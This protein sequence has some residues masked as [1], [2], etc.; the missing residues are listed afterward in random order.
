MN[1]FKNIN[2]STVFIFTVVTIIIIAGLWWLFQK[3]D[4]NDGQLRLYGNVDIREVQMAF[5]QPG[6]IAQMHFDEGDSVMPGMTLATLDDQPYQDTLASAQA[7]VWL[8]EA[9]L[10][11]TQAGL[12]PQEIEQAQ[13]AVNQ[14]MA[15]ATEAERNFQRQSKLFA[16]G[17]SSQRTLDMALAARKQS[18]AAV[19]SAKAALSQ[20]AEGFRVEDI[21]AAKARLASTQANLAQ[22]ITALADTKLIAPSS[23]T[24]IAR[25][26]EVGSMVTPQS[27]VYSLSLDSPVYIRAYISEPDLGRIAPGTS[28]WVS[29]DSSEKRYRGQVGFIS[30][31]AEF[32]PKTVETTELRTDLVYRIR[33][34]INEPEASKGLRQGMP[35]TIDVDTHA[36]L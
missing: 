22:T 17:A 15:T 11:K 9:E 2:R 6:R 34:V 30:P 33:I 4:N 35:V 3:P 14:A 29:N 8:A 23:G 13:Q 16:S 12:R 31:R 7:T 36:S 18:L 24:I 19:N 1:P 10:N 32:T 26:R 21:A 25:V 5:R 20:A 28:V 27:T